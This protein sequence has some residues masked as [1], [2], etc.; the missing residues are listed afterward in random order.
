MLQLRFGL[1]S[2]LTD[3]WYRYYSNGNHRFT[4]LHELHG[5]GT[6]DF[7]LTNDVTIIALAIVEY[8]ISSNMLRHVMWSK[9]TTD[10]YAWFVENPKL[11][12]MNNSSSSLQL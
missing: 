10:D 4:K 1:H 9:A 5:N 8:V 7:M 12:D 11:P 3:N 2:S 6:L